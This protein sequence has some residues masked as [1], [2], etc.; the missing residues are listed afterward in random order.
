M[1]MFNRAAV[2]PDAV[3]PH[4]LTPVVSE[5]VHSHTE[6]AP[7]TSIDTGVES[8]P[9]PVVLAALDQALGRRITRHLLADDAEAALHVGAMVLADHAIT[10][11]ANKDLQTNLLVNLV[12]EIAINEADTYAEQKGIAENFLRRCTLPPEYKKHVLK[13]VCDKDVIASS[14]LVTVAL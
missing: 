4:A 13:N 2:A 10:A 3:A 12:K 5:R 8:Y 7:Y 9:A 1:P 6:Y 14:Q 11:D